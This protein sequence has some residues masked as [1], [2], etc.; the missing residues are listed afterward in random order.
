M[1]LNELKE[2]AIFLKEENT[3]LH[4]EVNAKK[5]EF[6]QII[7]NNFEEIIL[8]YMWGMNDFIKNL[9][10]RF[11]EK[12]EQLINGNEVT[13]SK[14]LTKYGIKIL[15]KEW[16]SYGLDIYITYED[17]YKKLYADHWIS[18]A[19][20]FES[21]DACNSF[22]EQLNAD[23]S[24][25]IKSAIN[26]YETENPKLAETLQNLTERIRNSSFVEQKKDGSIEITINGKT[27]IGTV[28]EA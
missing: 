7:R 6:A 9:N 13:V 5:A 15:Y 21:V 10:F 24:L 2:K 23:Y 25:I 27:Y 16:K 20:F 8:P 18:L 22:I 4:N 11:D 19:E 26:Q 28:K 1:E 3:K 12:T 14:C 17:T